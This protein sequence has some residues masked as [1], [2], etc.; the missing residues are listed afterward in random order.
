M[1]D[2]GIPFE[3]LTLAQLI[4]QFMKSPA[5]TWRAF[6]VILGSQHGNV[7]AAAAASLPSTDQSPSDLTDISDLETPTAA[8]RERLVTGIFIT[9][10]NAQLLL[11]LIAVA[12]GLFGN[13]LLRGSGEM[14]PVAAGSLTAGAPFLWMSFFIWLLAELVGH[15]SQLQAW[16]HRIDRLSKF[17][18][19][20]RLLTL[21]IWLTSLLLLTDSM[22]APAESALG[23]VPAAIGRFAL[24]G[25]VW[26]LI[27]LMNRWLRQ[28]AAASSAS[29]DRAPPQETAAPQYP[30]PL[31]RKIVPARA[32]LFILAAAAS[33]LVWTNTANNQI[34]TPIIILWIASALLWALVFA[35]LKW[36]CFEWATERIDAVRRIHWREYSWAIIAFA[37]VM[38]LGMGFRLAQLE[39]HPPEMN[40]DLVEKIR[41]SNFVF[42]GDH[43]IFFS[44]NGGREPLQFYL[45][46]MLAALPGLD[47]NHFTLKLLGVLEGLATLPILV[48]VGIELM[49][50]RRRKFGLLVGLLLAGLVAVSYWH[51][52]LSR[53]GL[54]IVLTPLF[55]SLLMIYLARAMRRNRRADYVR[56]ALA[57]G[58]GL[59]G[60]QAM[61]MLPL[62]VVAGVV[63]AMAVRRISWRARLMY[64]INLAVL[65]FVSFMVFL[66]LFHYSLEEPEHFWRRTSGRILGDGV[67][68]E[69]QLEAFTSNV[70][71]LMSNI[72]NALL[73]FHWRGDITWLHG[74]PHEPA[75]DMFTG[76]FLMLG[77]AAWAVQMLKARDP[78]LWSVPVM[79]FIMLL[80]SALSI[81]FPIENPSHTRASGVMPLVYLVAAVPI[82]IIARHLR[83]AFPGRRGIIL[84]VIF[85]SS[86]ILFANQRNTRLYFDRYPDIY[87]E[88]SYPYSEAG[89]VLRGFANSGGAYGNAF[90][91]A[92]PYFWDHRAVGIEASE[93]FWP[94]SIVSLSDTPRFLDDARQR[95]DRF[96]LNPDR[97]LLFFY[98]PDDEATPLQ[99]RQWFPSGYEQRI[100][101]SHPDDSYLLYR[102][103]FLGEA[104]LE[105][106]LSSHS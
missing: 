92:Y 55:T 72:R 102:V 5:K 89:A 24:G 48:A 17:R 10:R 87:I 22:T 106:F 34:A 37:L 1:S 95:T 54:R 64:G 18:W 73:M 46:S 74:V 99:L 19:M 29:A 50:E 69:E 57:L 41:D 68:A 85:C 66:P 31:R 53:L 35:P 27:E 59:Y 88:A 42:E 4:H 70:P 56:A 3:D 80:P 32:A 47:F 52:A 14:V 15:W 13:S 39:A 63:I 12:C 7:Q 11:Y 26:L 105:A 33:L 94:N 71:I 36:N 90:I 60:Y 40:S 43:R 93:P 98:S 23:L 77:L 100:Q 38:I 58:F 30:L 2:N 61:R 49:G 82:A 101:S 6:N 97:D 62:I 78:V 44:N 76:A 103:P 96:K 16:W 65:V 67:A 9:I 84:A 75:M 51:A 21:L 25:L 81:A 91:I 86:L 79:I 83:Q 8:W 45:M 104:G 28:R 20:A